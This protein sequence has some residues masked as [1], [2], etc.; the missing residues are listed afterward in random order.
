MPLGRAQREIL[1]QTLLCH[2]GV[3]F[4]VHP[5]L[6]GSILCGRLL[7]LHT[8]TSPR[9]AQWQ[10]A[11]AAQATMPLPRAGLN[12]TVGPIGVH[13]LRHRHTIGTHTQQLVATG[14]CSTHSCFTVGAGQALPGQQQGSHTSQPTAAGQALWCLWHRFHTCNTE[15]QAAWGGPPAGQLRSKLFL[16]MACVTLHIAKAIGGSSVLHHTAGQDIHLDRPLVRGVGRLTLLGRGHTG[17][18]QCL[19]CIIS[20]I[21]QRCIW[22]KAGTSVPVLPALNTVGHTLILLWGMLSF[23]AKAGTLCLCCL[24]STLSFWVTLILG[25]GHRCCCCCCVLW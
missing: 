11:Q 10:C 16:C 13:Q 25:S 19:D 22:A 23:W 3:G 14:Q 21:I 17:L 7:Q 12:S 20:G 8:G 6:V 4:S 18:C 9:T 1:S 24:H 15:A 2:T 5:S